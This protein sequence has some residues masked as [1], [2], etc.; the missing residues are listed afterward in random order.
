MSQS[1]RLTNRCQSPERNIAKRRAW[2]ITRQARLKSPGTIQHVVVR[3]IEK[4][5]IKGFLWRR[6]VVKWG[7][8]LCR[9]PDD[10]TDKELFNIV[11]YVILIGHTHVDHP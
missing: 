2:R 5:R 9:F 4:K 8:H 10:P 11:N 1:T 6:Q 3:G 7:F